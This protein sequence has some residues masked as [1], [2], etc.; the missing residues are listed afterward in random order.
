MTSPGTMRQM[1]VRGP[2]RAYIGIGWL[3][4][5]SAASAR[6][7][8]CRSAGREATVKHRVLQLCMA[9]CLAGIAVLAGRTT[10]AS[11]VGPNVAIAASSPATENQ[12]QIATSQGH[13]VAVWFSGRYADEGGYSYSLDGG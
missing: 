4:A 3:R 8:C 5:S 13:I 7:C 12:P 9:A 10:A 2:R 1:P 11:T 6:W